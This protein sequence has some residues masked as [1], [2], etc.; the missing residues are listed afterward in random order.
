MAALTQSQATAGPASEFLIKFLLFG[1]LIGLL[2][3]SLSAL[4]GPASAAL[5][6]D[7]RALIIESSLK[8]ISAGNDAAIANQ[9]LVRSRGVDSLGQPRLDLSRERP[10]SAEAGIEAEVDSSLHRLRRETAILQSTD[11]RRSQ[12]EDTLDRAAK[13]P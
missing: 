7:Q 8:D 5:A 2:L 9:Q 3:A 10:I 11:D 1:L 13:A 6:A 12:V 4:A